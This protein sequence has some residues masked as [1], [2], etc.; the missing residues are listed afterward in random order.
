VAAI[1]ALGAFG[2]RGLVLIA[3]GQGKGLAYG[4]LANAIAGH[5]RT[6]VLIGETAGELDGLIAGRVPVIR[7]GSMPEAVSAAAEAARPGDIVLLAPAAASFDMFVDY[8]ARGDAFRSA[9][10]ALPVPE[11]ER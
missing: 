5:C 4:E 9:V 10:A 1:A 6:A 8:A 2:D 11:G 3:G 7:A